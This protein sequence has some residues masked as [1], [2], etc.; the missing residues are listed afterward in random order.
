MR[1]CVCLLALLSMQKCLCPHVRLC[2]STLLLAD[3]EHRYL[4][5]SPQSFTPPFLFF[6]FFFVL[7]RADGGC[8]PQCYLFLAVAV[9]FALLHGSTRE[10]TTASATIVLCGTV[11]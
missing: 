11:L 4:C 1:H 2:M 3:S 9:A 8:V 6:L 10:V 5:I 7:E